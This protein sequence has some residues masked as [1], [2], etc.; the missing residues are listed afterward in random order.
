MGVVLVLLLGEI[1]LSVGAVS[2][3]AAAVTAVLSVKHGWNPYL[4]IVAGLLTG[5]AI[6]VFQGF[7]HTRLLIPSF[8]VTLAGLLAWQGA[9]LRV[10]G[11]TGTVNL[12][13]PAITN[14][15][16][17]FLAKWLGWAAAIAGVAAIILM[18]VRKRARRRK[19]ELELE[20]LAG[21]VLRVVASATAIVVAVAV[22]N[23]DRGVSLA[24]IILIASSSSCTA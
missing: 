9:H 15:A 13:D 10:L 21:M 2:G 18:T 22:V 11:S 19:L 17:V 3:L 4:A 16:G 23:S 20:P 24:F 8:V 14:I 12:S 1:D 5:T 7:I 6:G